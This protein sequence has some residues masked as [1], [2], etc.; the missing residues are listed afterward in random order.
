MVEMLRC[1]SDNRRS[2][3]GASHTVAPLTT[4]LLKGAGGMAGSNRTPRRKPHNR[5]RIQFICDS[6]G[7]PFLRAP[8]RVNYQRR[9]GQSVVCSR[10]CRVA[11]TRKT[12][13]QKFMEKVQKS[14]GCWIWTGMKSKNGYGQF[15][16]F[17]AMKSA[18]RFSWEL[19]NG[20][21]IPDGMF[22]CHSYDNKSCVNP[23]HL[24]VG[25]PSDNTADAVTK[26]LFVQVGETHHLAKLTYEK[27][28]QLRVLRAQGYSYAALGRLFGVSPTCA[29]AAAR[30]KT[31]RLRLPRRQEGE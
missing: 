16:P 12:E 3:N 15:G 21:P 11:G 29:S 25:S 28:G 8:S 5:A 24:F 13:E 10:A 4:P 18:H 14:D 23:A 17:G 22:A 9:H 19:A 2:A 7:A 31:W 30:G 27:V 26:G 20:R 6:C 1:W